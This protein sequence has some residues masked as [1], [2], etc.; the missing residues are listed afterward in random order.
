MAAPKHRFAHQ[1]NHNTQHYPR[2]AELLAGREVVLDVGCG[3]GT[4]ARYLAECGHQVIGIDR[5]PDVL[6]A[7]SEGTHYLLADAN[8]LPFPADSFDAVVSVMVLHHTRMELALTEMRRVIKPGGLLVDLGYARDKGL[9]E[10]LRSA[11]D[12]PGDLWARRGKTRWEPP[13]I[14]ADAQLGWAETRAV[15]DKMLPGSNWQ[16]VAGWRYL[17]SWQ[18]DAE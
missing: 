16:R 11:A 6:P 2:I 3:D 18:R 13:T 8:A 17:A 10:L 14:T 9:G 7:D 12:I 15:F 5:D 4:L 1:W